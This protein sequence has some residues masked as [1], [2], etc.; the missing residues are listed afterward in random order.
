[1]KIEHVGHALI[2][3]VDNEAETDGLGRAMAS[4][5]SPGVV[6]G[7]I[8]PLGA[9]KTRLARSIAEALGVDPNAIGSP[10]F[11][12]IHEYEGSIPIFHFDTYRLK[13]AEE[14]DDLGAAEYWAAGGICLVEWADRFADRLP[15]DAWIVSVRPQEQGRVFSIQLPERFQE[16]LAN[17][18]REGLD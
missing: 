11:G 3:H 8:G 9:G 15:T 12:L 7:L 4:L 5:A 16:A 18:L 10:T 1:M 6:I 13:T 14:F 17:Q 2:V